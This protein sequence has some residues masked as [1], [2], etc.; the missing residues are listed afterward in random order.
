MTLSMEWNAGKAETNLRK[1]GVSFEEAA[2]A[3]AD[4][5]GWIY[6]DPLH[7]D[8]ELREILIGE[9]SVGRLLLVCFT[10]RQNNI[11]RIISSRIPTKH[12]RQKYEAE[13]A[14]L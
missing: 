10:E 9:S 8:E 3:F 12:E 14:H 2:T 6:P 13:R 7:S 4:P 11:I 1:H 5:L